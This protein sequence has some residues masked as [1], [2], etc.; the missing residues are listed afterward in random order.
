VSL[1]LATTKPSAAHTFFAGD[2]GAL[3]PPGFRILSVKAVDAG[4]FITADKR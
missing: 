4:A 2:T 3:L 1:L